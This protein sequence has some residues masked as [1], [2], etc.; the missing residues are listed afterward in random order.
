MD[1]LVAGHDVSVL[2]ID[3]LVVRVIDRISVANPGW[4]LS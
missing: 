3:T 4:P 1:T 2:M